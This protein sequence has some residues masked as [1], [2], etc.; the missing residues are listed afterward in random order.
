M[1]K[2]AAIT[3]CVLRIDT[4]LHNTPTAADQVDLLRQFRAADRLGPPLA[5]TGNGRGLLVK[6]TARSG[7]LPLGQA[8]R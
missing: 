2:A 1:H 3:G 8:R 6:M 7:P 4:Y 5:R